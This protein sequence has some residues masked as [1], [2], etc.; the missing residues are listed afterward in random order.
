MTPVKFDG[1]AAPFTLPVVRRAAAKVEDGAVT[2]TLYV[3]PEDRSAQVPV[4]IRMPARVAHEFATEFTG[5]I[6]RVAK[7]EE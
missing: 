4:K 7:A 2:I 6:A 1:N 3:V 5:A